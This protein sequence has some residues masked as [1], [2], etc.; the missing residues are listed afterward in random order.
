MV[1][2]SALKSYRKKFKKFTRDHLVIQTIFNVALKLMVNFDET[3]KSKLNSICAILNDYLN[4]HEAETGL[5]VEQADFARCDLQGFALSGTEFDKID[6]TSHAVS[7]ET[8][9]H[10]DSYPI[11]YK[12]KYNER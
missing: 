9:K 11:I 4:Q 8:P 2:P 3:I 5:V 1:P 12:L 10:L 7:V 6:W